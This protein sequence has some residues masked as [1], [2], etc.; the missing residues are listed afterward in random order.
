[1][2]RKFWKE[3]AQKLAQF[4]NVV[5][6]YVILFQIINQKKKVI[7]GMKMMAANNTNVKIMNE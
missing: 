3:K 2:K 4:M 6:K 7:L 5:I 1:M